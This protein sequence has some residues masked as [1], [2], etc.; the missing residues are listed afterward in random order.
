MR[1]KWLQ[2]AERNLDEIGAYIAE[3]NA[4]AAEHLVIKIIE[5]VTL[6]ADH[7]AIGRAGRFPGTREL[8]VADTP[9]IVIYRVR[10]TFLEVLRIL[11]GARKWPPS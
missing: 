3:D 8:V 2:I 1:V 9:Y 4:D 10:D 7:P 5:T 11:H 6:L